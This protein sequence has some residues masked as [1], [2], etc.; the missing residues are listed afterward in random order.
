[1]LLSDLN[2]ACS[3][4]KISSAWG[5]SLFKMT[6]S[7]TLLG[8]LIR[9]TVLYFWQSCMLPFLGSIIIRSPWDLSF[10]CFP[11]LIQT[12]VK[13]SITVS[14]PAWTSSAGI[15]VLSIPVDYSF[16]VQLLRSELPH[17]RLSLDLLLGADYSPELYFYHNSHS[18]KA[19]SNTLSIC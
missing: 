5:L 4:A 18:C 1:M 3:S 8:W 11:D 9:L 2:P 7:M 17:E 13:T 6:V 14:T 15:H 19:R 12:F 16:L 10:P